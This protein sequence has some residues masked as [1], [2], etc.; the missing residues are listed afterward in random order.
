VCTHISPNIG[1]RALSL[2]SSTTVFFWSPHISKGLPP[3]AVATEIETIRAT[4][5]IIVFRA[6]TDRE[7]IPAGKTN[8]FSSESSLIFQ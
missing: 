3:A 1:C 2:N 4:V 8:G 6:E 5:K 7:N